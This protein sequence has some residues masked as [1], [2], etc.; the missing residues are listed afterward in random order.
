M[1]IHFLFRYFGAVF[2][3]FFSRYA[4]FD[5]KEK[6]KIKRY[7]LKRA[8]QSCQLWVIRSGSGRKGGELR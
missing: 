3:F 7:N 4:L 5:I 2:T 6:L 8:G 1:D